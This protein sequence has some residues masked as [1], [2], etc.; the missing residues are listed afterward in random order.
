MKPGKS[1]FARL[2][3]A[4]GYSW[5]G[6]KAAWENE[7]A[8]RQEVVAVVILLPLAY[9]IANNITQ[10]L[11]LTTPLFILL[12]AELVN[13]ALESVVD[14]IGG[15][16]HE[17]SGR[18]KDLGSAVVFIALLLSFVTWSLVLVENYVL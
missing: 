8:F 18:A 14:R 4:T 7:A 13:S 9:L 15:E 10:F 12:I 16:H 17:L 3:D 11:L 6:L 5:M 2:I 1:G